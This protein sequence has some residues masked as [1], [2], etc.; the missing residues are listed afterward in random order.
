MN[1]PRK[2]TLG[3]VMALIVV[4][5]LILALMV[6]TRKATEQKD[7]LQAEIDR[8]RA[9]YE[10]NGE[11]IVYPSPGYYNANMSDNNGSKEQR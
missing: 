7:R 10:L 6:Q 4:L 9:R 8:L 2:F 11:P 3:G 5:S 1:R